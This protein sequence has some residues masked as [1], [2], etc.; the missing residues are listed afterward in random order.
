MTPATA[1]IRNARERFVA[2]RRLAARR[3]FAVRFGA[4]AF[5]FR[6]ALRDLGAVRFAGGFA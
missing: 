1:T 3:G 2:L 6:G 5:G 4:L